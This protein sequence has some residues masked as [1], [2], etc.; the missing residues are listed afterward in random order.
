MSSETGHPRGI[1]TQFFTEMWERMSYYG[2][3]A[4]L[5][6]FM[7]DHMRDSKAAT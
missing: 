2:I 5:V 7:V 4:L 6:L 1:Y 3:R